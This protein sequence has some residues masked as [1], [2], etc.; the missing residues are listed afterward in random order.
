MPVHSHHTDSATAAQLPDLVGDAWTTEVVSALPAALDEQART[1]KAF[2]RTRGL[3]CPSDLLRAILAYVLA[4]LSFRALGIW[5]VLLGL[6]DIIGNLR[7]RR[8]KEFLGLL[9]QAHMSRSGLI[10]DRNSCLVLDGLLRHL[11]Q[12]VRFKTR[13]IFVG[14][15]ASETAEEQPADFFVFQPFGAR[16]DHAV[17]RCGGAGG[18]ELGPPLRNRSEE[19]AVLLDLSADDIPQP[20]DL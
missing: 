4:N 14:R 7:D 12:Q 17:I 19:V 6:A 11:H 1:L 10:K 16:T 18:A 3:E 15:S 5:A 20:V 9:S 8:V 13:L 2:Q